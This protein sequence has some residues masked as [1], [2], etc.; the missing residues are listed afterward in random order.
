MLKPVEVKD[1][2]KGQESH[3]EGVLSFACCCQVAAV[4]PWGAGWG[5]APC[6]C[7]PHCP[8]PQGHVPYFFPEGLSEGEPQGGVTLPSGRS[9]GYSHV[10]RQ[11]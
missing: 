9:S 4:L 7:V 3:G 5:W 1:G 8:H 10:C 2:S 11:V 6:S